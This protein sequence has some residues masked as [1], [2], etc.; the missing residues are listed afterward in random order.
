MAIPGRVGYQVY[1]LSFSFLNFSF[2]CLFTCYFPINNNFFFF[3][4]KIKCSNYYR[5]LV[6][7][8][9]VIDKNY[10]IDGDGKAHYIFRT[11]STFLISLRLIRLSLMLF[12]FKKKKNKK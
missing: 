10:I 12:F 1:F 6:E 5:Q 9:E 7:R 8:G 2:L 4:K 3:Q 11:M